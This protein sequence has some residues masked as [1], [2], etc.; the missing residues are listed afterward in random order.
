[1]G[2]V[3]DLDHLQAQAGRDEETPRSEASSA[4]ALNGDKNDNQQEDQPLDE[5]A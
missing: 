1:L 5:Q 2:L 3:V 4:M